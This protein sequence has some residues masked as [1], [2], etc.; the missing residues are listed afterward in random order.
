MSEWTHTLTVVVPELLMS[1]ANQLA[2]AMGTSEDDVNTFTSASW[3][4]GTDRF[5][6]CSTR[7]TESIFDSFGKLDNTDNPELAEA[8]EKTIF[9]QFSI[10]IGGSTSLLNNDATKIRIITDMEPLAA[11]IQLG[12][13]RLDL[14]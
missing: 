10:D 6:V 8:M 12:L 4:D 9:V 11:L 5:A 1:Q 7:A 3:S 13:S 14:N 2:L